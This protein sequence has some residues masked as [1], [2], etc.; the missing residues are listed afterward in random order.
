[1]RALYFCIVCVLLTP[2]MWA[3]SSAV[4]GLVADPSGGVVAHATVTAIN[5]TT[6]LER[7]MRTSAVGRYM[8]QF[9][10]AGSYRIQVQA[11][12]F[13][14]A[15]RTSVGL[16]VAQTA[17]VDFTLELGE[18][19]QEIAVEA[20]AAI[21][22][23][24]SA[25]LGSMAGERAVQDLPLNGRNFVT[26]AQLSGGA[27]ESVPFALS[28]GQRPDDRRRT[29]AFAVNGQRDFLNNFLIDGM[30]NNERSI[31]TSVVKPSIEAVAEFKVLTNLY[32]A[33]YGRTGG[34][35]VNLVTRSGSN[36]W[37]GSAFEFWRNEKLDAKNFFDPA[38]PIAPFRQNQ[39]GGSLGGPLRRGRTFFFGDYE[40]LRVRQA[41]TYVSSVPTE[42]MKAGDFSE[43]GAI[44]DPGTTRPDPSRPGVFV[45]DRFAGDRIPAGLIDSIGAR[46]IGLYPSLN[47]SGVSNNFVFNPVKKQR[48][49]TFDARFDNHV[50]ERDTFYVRYS[51]NDTN[52]FLPPHLPRA[53]DIEA[54]GDK[55]QFAGPTLQR[56]LGLHLNHVHV[57]SPSRL[58]E[59]K[60]GYS[61]F[62]LASLPTNFGNSASQQLGIPG[63]NID[64]KTSG[65]VQVTVAGFRDLGDSLWIPLIVVNNTFQY[66]ANLSYTRLR[67]N[68]R[69]GADIR[70]RQLGLFQSPAPK[71]QFEFNSNFTNDPSGAAPNSGSSL[72]SLLLGLPAVTDR[73]HQVVV[74]GYRT[75]EFSA[76]VQDDWRIQ[77]WL[78]FNIGVRY[79]LFTPFVEVADRASNIDFRTGR[80]II[81][82][83]NGVSRSAGVEGDHN[84]F[85]PRVGFAATITP[86]T[87][88]RG[89]YG[90][91]YHPPLAGSDILYRNPPFVSLYHIDA[92][93]LQP[94]NRLS[95]GFP[96]PVPSD[97][98]RPTGYLTAIDF[99]LR[100][101]YVQ[102]Y[103]L[104]LQREVMRSVIINVGYVAALARKQLYTPDV[105]L[106][107][108]GPGDIEKRRPYATLIPTAGPI[109]L[110]NSWGSGNYHS[111]QFTAERQFRHG[112]QFRAH[113]TWAHAIDDNQ[114]IG[115]GK[116]SAGPSPQLITNRG[117][118][119]GNSDIDLR[120]RLALL[121]N[122]ALPLGSNLTGVPARIIRG[123]QV[124]GILRLQTGLPFSVFNASPLANTG[125]GDRPNRLCNGT[126]A[127]GERTLQ[128]YFNTSCFA[129]QPLF[130]I[131]DA[132]RNLLFAPSLKNLD[133]SVLKD[134]TVSERMRLQ[135]RAEFFNLTNTPHF[136]LPNGALGSGSFGAISDTGTNTARQI[137]LALKLLF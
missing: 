27:H 92:T 120:H 16:A 134:F 12:G 124:N 89:G 125:G 9:L 81:A 85:A 58:G 108:P 107:P 38:G 131:G 88:I 14:K 3:Q 122:Y 116:P 60:A 7:S 109:K 133:F 50:S 72:A 104:T 103:N 25:Q 23:T 115:T 110:A 13:R 75:T 78:T 90:I 33:E 30:D 52:T 31:G 34:G 2:C 91:A 95:Q 74:P 32:S 123:W 112:L 20:N 43:V 105:N 44:F 1:M 100:T 118:E 29:S 26:L 46:L 66:A 53:G 21:L 128:R 99:G 41:Q 65:L 86:K 87:V 42:K 97:P 57:F 102:H 114:A 59:F 40:A 55:W 96:L 79:D 35:V 49:D 132:A 93:P 6:G 130:Q 67:H 80:A 47:L 117:L 10:P 136:G 94:I 101:G 98:N 106:A 64:D 68:V 11:A 15:A 63:A 24:E 54:G 126:L 28:S 111:L 69:F 22:D 73:Q 62:A 18:V 56:S 129:A 71:G 8:I 5:G 137:Q 82:G 119:R 76:Y 37:H 48:D 4:T 113:Y 39:F 84:N 19:P 45:R 135:F 77:P 51:F 70:R 36:Q 127:S 83:Q 61:R 121:W 17:R